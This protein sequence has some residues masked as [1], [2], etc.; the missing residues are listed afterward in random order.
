[1]K[2][3]LCF[4][5]LYILV[6]FPLTHIAH[7]K[8]IYTV[9][10][11]PQFEA[12]RIAEIWQPILDEISQQSGIQL[13][14]K[15]PS[16]IPVF[17][18]QLTAGEFDFAYMNP[19]H[20]IISNES[21][22]YTPLL[23]D[24]GRSLFG[25]IVVKKDSP[26]QSVNELNGKTVA[27]PSPNA[28]GATLLPRAELARKVNIKVDELYVKSHSSVYLNVLLGKA[29]AG[30]GVQKTLAQQPDKIR[31][32]L[33]VLYKTTEVPSHPLTAHP[34]V[35]KVI[36]DKIK[37]AFIELGN[38]ETGKNLLKNIPMKQIG[39]ASIEDYEPLKRMGLDKFYVGK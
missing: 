30:G 20:A 10:V 3:N 36:Q 37:A 5:V 29:V 12:R 8:N 2:K 22:G 19:Y 39:E 1:M 27:F 17:E 33:R 7:A 9:G 18:K 34:R 38:S 13:E 14:L 15:T 11:V 6:T 21:Q 24:T 32:Q 35:D 16:S 25:V 26:I 31:D 23:R 28:L 4:A